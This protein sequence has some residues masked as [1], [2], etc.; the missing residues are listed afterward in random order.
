MEAHKNGIIT[1]S[2]Q[3]IITSLETFGRW[4]VSSNLGAVT[5]TGIIPHKKENKKIRVGLGFYTFCS[6]K[7]EQIGTKKNKSMTKSRFQKRSII[8]SSARSISS[9]SESITAA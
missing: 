4:D 1:G 3:S 6:Q 2:A 7:K 5:R 9:R 8:T